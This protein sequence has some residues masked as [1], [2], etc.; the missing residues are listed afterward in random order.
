MGE[1]IQYFETL[2]PYSDVTCEVTFSTGGSLK[3]PIE[4][5]TNITLCQPQYIYSSVGQNVVAC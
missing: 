3:R 5:N 2:L 4:T 1:K